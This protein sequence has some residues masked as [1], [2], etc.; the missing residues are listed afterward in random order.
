MTLGGLR[1][2][3]FPHQAELGLQLDLQGL[4][5]P[6]E[7]VDLTAGRLEGLCAAGHHLV[8]LIKLGRTEGTQ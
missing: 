4:K 6:L 8:Q 1:G 3:L 2:H 5:G 7:L